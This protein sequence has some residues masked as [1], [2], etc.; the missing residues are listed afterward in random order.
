MRR[1]EIAAH[2]FGRQF[3]KLNFT[4]KEEQMATQKMV[5]VT[6]TDAHGIGYSAGSDYKVTPPEAKRLI[7]LKKA[8][9]KIEPKKETATAKNSKIEK[10]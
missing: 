3:I 1:F 5:W 10:R 2:L 9:P 7:E 4:I 6:I 8:K